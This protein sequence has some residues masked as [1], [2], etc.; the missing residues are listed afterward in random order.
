MN[1]SA[2]LTVAGRLY[3][4]LG[5][6]LVG[7]VL[8]GGYAGLLA[9]HP[10][11]RRKEVDASGAGRLQRR[12]HPGTIRSLQG[13]QD[14]RGRCPAPGQGQPAQEPLQQRCRLLLHLRL[15]GRQPDARLEARARR[16]ELP[17][18]EGSERQGIHQG[19]DRPAQ[20]R[21]RRL[22]RLHVSQGRLHRSH[23]E[24][25]LRQGLPALGLVGWHRRLHRGRRSRFP[26]LGGEFA[27]LS[28]RDR[29]GAWRPGPGHQPQRAGA[30]RRRTRCGRR[31]GRGIR[32]RRPD[33]A[34]HVFQHSARQ[35]AGDAWHHADRLADIVRGIRSSTEVLA[36]ESADLSIAAKEISLGDGEAGRI[37]RGHGGGDRG[38][39]RQ[40][41][42]GIGD[43]PD[44]REELHHDGGT[45]RQGRRRRPSVRRPRSRTSPRQSR[46]RRSASRPWSAAPRR[47][48]ASPR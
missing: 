46:V 8:M 36:K 23:T 48:A 4:L 3:L 24:G 20:A 27:G 12:R 13:R 43:R 17:R 22:H 21:R 44:H 10:Y 47:S 34:D 41:Q 5:A 39:D 16:Q 45:R 42:R 32:W 19:V 33:P 15:R 30:D 6:M 7:L 28:G 35:P 9:A 26:P 2:G 25:V 40:H 38:T 18:L 14:Q 37:E 29:R 1:K 31:A 11:P